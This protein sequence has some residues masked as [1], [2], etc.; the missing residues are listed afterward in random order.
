MRSITLTGALISITLACALAAP[1]VAGATVRSFVSTRCSVAPGTNS[2]LDS[3]TGPVSFDIP[4]FGG[5]TAAFADTASHAL[6]GYSGAEAGAAG[7]SDDCTTNALVRNTLTVG[8]GTTGLSP[9]SP[10]TLRLDVDLTG[11]VDGNASANVNFSG[12]VDAFVSYKLTGQQFVCG[13][14]G[15]E[16]PEFASLVFS[17][18][19]DMDWSLGTPFDPNGSITDSL[20]WSWDLTSNAAPAQGDSANEYVEV[21]P[22]FPSTCLGP[23]GLPLGMQPFQ[24]P[25]GS[26]SIEFR[27][28]VGAQ[29]DLEGRLNILSQAYGPGYAFGDVLHSLHAAVSPA[30]GYTGLTLSYESNPVAP[31]ADT[32]PPTIQCATPA[33]GWH[34]GNVSVTCTASDSGSGLQ[35]AADAAFTLSTNVAAGSEDAGAQTGTRQV[36]DIA[37]NCAIAGPIGGIEVDRKP[38]SL[39][40]PAGLTVNATTPLGA[41][42]TFSPNA[43]DGGS[44]VASASCGLASTLVPVGQTLVTCTATD[45]A[46]NATTANLIVTVK[47]AKEQLGD[48]VQKIVNA[49]QLS[50]AAKTLLIGKLNQLLASFDPSNATQRQAVCLALQLF[51]TA[52]QLQAGAAITPAQ[53]AEWIADASRIRAVLAC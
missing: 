4:H 31:P 46:G 44:G 2:Q 15:C 20:R 50:P 53:A 7:T 23:G 41:S 21:C 10:V 30:A 51:K 13:V 36:C 32:T 49:S 33:A 8:A 12:S 11:D 22:A 40:L 27:T 39:N 14:E 16:L 52:V 17:L 42:V 5:P 26:R 38:P 34:A 18:A 9:G 47:G 24:L 45:N 1:A 6:G 28:T 43:A 3:A 35:N 37:G 19:R 29:I 25:V 48:L